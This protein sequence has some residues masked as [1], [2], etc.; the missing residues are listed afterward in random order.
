M[1]ALNEPDDIQSERLHESIK[2]RAYRF[3]EEKDIEAARS[4]LDDELRG[5]L[6]YIAYAL[7]VVQESGGQELS[8]DRAYRAALIYLRALTS[9][10]AFRA[11][12]R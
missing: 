2:M 9:F 4:N 12:K 5:E 6:P 3:L 8:N 11:D 7:S 10:V 1:E